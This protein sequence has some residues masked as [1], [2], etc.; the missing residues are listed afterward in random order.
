MP[1]G[2]ADRTALPKGTN[3][4]VLCRWCGLEVPKGR[5]TFCSDWCV[6]EWRLRSDPGYLRQQVL[7]RDRGI[8]AICHTDTCAAYLDIRRSRG[9]HRQVL[10]AKWGLAGPARKSLWDA[11]HILPVAEGGGECDLENLRTLC[12]LCHRKQTRELRSRLLARQCQA[13]SQRFLPFR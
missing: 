13:P 4:R 5:F 2:A 11:D 1:G 3:G 9:V 12:I 7:A 6:H 8:C 10:L